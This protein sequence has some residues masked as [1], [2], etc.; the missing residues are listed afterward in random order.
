MFDLKDSSENRKNFFSSE[1]DLGRASN[2]LEY[3]IKRCN[4]KEILWIIRNISYD[5]VSYWDK[6]NCGIIYKS[7][8]YS[9]L[10]REQ[11]C[12]IQRD[13]STCCDL[14]GQSIIDKRE[15]EEEYINHRYNYSYM[16][17][18]IRAMSEK[19]EELRSKLDEEI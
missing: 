16:A 12:Q 15:F 8:K 14:F 3:L 18:T 7:E 6:D 1:F 13:L 11:A 10:N 2:T 17:G 19:I 9:K 5:M 4:L